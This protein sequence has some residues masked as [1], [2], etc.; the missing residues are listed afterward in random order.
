MILRRLIFYGL[1]FAVL[2]AFGLASK[3]KDIQPYPLV[4]GLA[5]RYLGVNLRKGSTPAVDLYAMSDVEM[6]THAS[7]IIRLRT[8]GD[9]AAL[10]DKI[11]E[12]I[13]GPAGPPRSEPSAVRSVESLDW[14]DVVTLK[15]SQRIVIPQSN[16]LDAA[17]DVLRPVTPT[18]RIAIW[19]SDD[20]VP[21]PHA[22]LGNLLAKGTTIALVS[23]PTH[24]GTPRPD[25]W[26]EHGTVSFTTP[27]KLNF[28]RS[29]EAVAPYFFSPI[30]LAV[31]LLAK[32]SV[33]CIDLVGLASTAMVAVIY[34]A[35]DP[36]ICATIAL[37]A[38][39]PP[40]VDRVSPQES[41]DTAD[42]Y[43]HANQLELATM[44][45]L[46]HGRSLTEVVL[47]HDVNSGVVARMALYGPDVDHAVRA[48]GEGN[49]T[50]VEDTSTNYHEFSR[51][52]EDI[53]LKTLGR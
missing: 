23:L 13:W 14:R 45:A 53:V 11:I 47:A 21:A 39:S 46:G 29:R 35:V 16:G 7:E 27:E 4:A 38:P 52:M 15:E 37:I 9:V 26:T 34:A 22:V 2:Y 25:I 1:V 12:A 10:R 18:N 49:F 28:L 30:A 51:T 42:I 36:R 33:A 50:G 3:A 20:E 6:A 43:L 5:E 31:D 32:D 8:S 24:E 17:I 41:P 44:A 48:L 19:L 40:F